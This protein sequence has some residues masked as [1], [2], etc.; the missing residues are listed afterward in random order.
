[1]LTPKILFIYKVSIDIIFGKFSR[2][3]LKLKLTLSVKIIPFSHEG[4]ILL[5]LF[6]ITIFC[7]TIES[8]KKLEFFVFVPARLCFP[9]RE[10][11]NHIR[12]FKRIYVCNLMGTLKYTFKEN[13]N[14]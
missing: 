14:K 1:M 4:V 12:F 6:F 13:M 10:G 11:L 2:E 3:I 7:Y 8:I 5:L 9:Y